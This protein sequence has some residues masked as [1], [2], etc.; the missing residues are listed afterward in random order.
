MMTK[1]DFIALGDVVSLLKI[2][3]CRQRYTQTE[4][5]KEIGEVTM[6]ESFVESLASFC[7]TQNPRFNREKWIK[8]VNQ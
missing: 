8:Y 2:V 3:D 7:A 6:W 4:H 1:K 5:A